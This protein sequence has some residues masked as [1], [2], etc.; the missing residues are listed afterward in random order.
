MVQTVVSLPSVLD[1][2][3]LAES[4]LV[5]GRLLLFLPESEDED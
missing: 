1:R 5:N 4:F 3:F 2:D